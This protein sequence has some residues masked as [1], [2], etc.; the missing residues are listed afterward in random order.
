M[1][2]E[3]T[4]SEREQIRNLMRK[5]YLKVATDDDVETPHITLITPFIYH[6]IGLLELVERTRTISREEQDML[7]EVGVTIDPNDEIIAL[8]KE[9]LRETSRALEE[10][11]QSNIEELTATWDEHIGQQTDT[12][13]DYLTY[14]QELDLS[15]LK[16]GELPDNLTEDYDSIFP[17][18]LY[19][20][21]TNELT[22][23]H[24]TTIV[25]KL[26]N[27]NAQLIIKII[28]H[29]TESGWDVFYDDE[30]FKKRTREGDYFNY[31]WKTRYVN[32]PRPNEIGEY[33]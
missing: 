25:N 33:I 23:H 26:N 21:Y 17:A 22:P 2:R 4:N 13:N 9:Q 29:T 12:F 10:I 16:Q 28:Q 14:L 7:D 31:S 24:A 6:N 1:G 5:I 8:N 20:V 19:Y 3:A 30:E 11:P 15:K 18:I 32:L 27:K